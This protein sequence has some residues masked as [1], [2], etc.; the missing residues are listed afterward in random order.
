[1]C[2][3]MT[4]VAHSAMARLRGT[5]VEAHLQ[6]NL[7]LTGA[8]L[9]LGKRALILISH[10]RAECRSGVLGMLLGLFETTNKMFSIGNSANEINHLRCDPASKDTVSPEECCVA[11]TDRPSGRSLPLARRTS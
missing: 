3:H 6:V 11:Q 7:S 8:Q 10:L 5:L 4:C 9:L 1:M 2:L